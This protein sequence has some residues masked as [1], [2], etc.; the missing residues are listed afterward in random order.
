MSARSASLRSSARATI[1]NVR[2]FV[3]GVAAVEPAR[4]NLRFVPPTDTWRTSWTLGVNFTW[5]L[6]DS[7]RSRA[8]AGA[9]SAQA[10]AVDARRREVDSLIALEIRQRLLETAAG[11]AA[12]AASA[13]AVTAAT[14]ARRVVEERFRAGVASNSDVLDAQ[15]ALLEAEVEQSRLQAGL[16]VTEARLLRAV[17]SR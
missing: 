9:L 6:W 11:Q 16:R 7:G 1:A 4:P 14:E 3:T 8:E 12:I 5:P 13:D 15:L 2:P 10:D 17:G